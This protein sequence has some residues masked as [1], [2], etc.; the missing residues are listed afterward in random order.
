VP[1]LWN[2]TVEAHRTQVRDAIVDSAAALVFEHGLR[3]VTMSQIAEH[4]GIGRATLYKY[5]PDVDAILRTWHTRRVEEHLAELVRVRA[6]SGTAGTR[7]TA[8]LRSYAHGMHRAGGHDRGLVQALH[9]DEQISDARNRL[10]ELISELI[11]EAADSGE[12]RDDIAADELADYS[13]H[14]LAAAAEL[15]SAAAVDRLVAVTA[16]GLR[17]QVEV[18]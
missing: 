9:P 12:L 17:L 2:E 4:A 3:A 5:F 7:L 14:A 10:R 11:T 6:G 16:A 18:E 15:G 1:K 8:V 13:L